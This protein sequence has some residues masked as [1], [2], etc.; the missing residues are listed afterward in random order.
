MNYP[1]TIIILIDNPALLEILQW[2]KDR[3]LFRSFKTG[4]GIG[5]YIDIRGDLLDYKRIT[6]ETRTPAFYFEVSFEDNYFSLKP[7]FFDNDTKILERVLEDILIR[8]MDGMEI[9]SEDEKY[10]VV[11]EPLLFT[12]LKKELIQKKDK[13]NRAYSYVY[14]W[15]WQVQEGGSFDEKYEY[16]PLCGELYS[17]EG[18]SEERY[19][20]Y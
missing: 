13:I 18:D 2:Y 14:C 4:F 6:A 3:G 17:Y 5:T 7:G 16:D 15:N 8:A 9:E 11:F 19:F 20:Y 12:Q 10:Q 1:C